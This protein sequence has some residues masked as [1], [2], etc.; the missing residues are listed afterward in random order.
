LSTWMGDHDFHYLPES[1][2]VAI[3]EVSSKN[4]EFYQEVE[5][6]IES[7][8]SRI[9]QQ[10]Q[11]FLNEED[12][13]SETISRWLWTNHGS[14]LQAAVFKAA[15]RTK[16]SKE[17]CSDPVRVGLT[18]SLWAKN[19]IIEIM[20]GATA[21]V[22][23]LANDHSLANPATLTIIERPH[24]EGANAM[25]VPKNGY[26]VIRFHTPLGFIG[27][28][29]FKYQV[30][31][32]QTQHNCADARVRASVRGHSVLARNDFYEL[33]SNPQLHK[34]CPLENDEHTSTDS[35]IKFS[36]GRAI[37]REKDITEES[38]LANNLYG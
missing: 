38:E 33:P 24:A 26:S 21:D 12:L 23:V 16:S 9:L 5:A 30:C 34:I 19:D 7:E 13:S 36:R 2:E 37:M 10:D 29:S 11:R 28:E 15:N 17:D 20:E 35:M 8:I 3:H 27:E 32:D 22:V 1:S 31:T 14:S 6:T 18:V 25:V 4:Y